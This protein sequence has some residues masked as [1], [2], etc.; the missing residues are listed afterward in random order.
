MVEEGGGVDG[1]VGELCVGGGAEAKL[2]CHL[3]SL[4]QQPASVVETAK[5]L[6]YEVSWDHDANC[7]EMLIITVFVQIG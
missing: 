2:L 4:G 7:L 3:N 6:H 5:H 1:A